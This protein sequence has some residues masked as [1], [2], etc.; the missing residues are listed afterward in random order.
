MQRK[1]QLAPFSFSNLNKV[2]FVPFLNPNGN[3]GLSPKFLCIL[4]FAFLVTWG[5]TSLL[6]NSGSHAEITPVAFLYPPPPTH[7]HTDADVEVSYFYFPPN[8]HTRL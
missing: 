7:T 1:C 3:L 6:L 5:A 2:V 8:T 4:G